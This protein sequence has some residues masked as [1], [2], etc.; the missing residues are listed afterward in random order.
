MSAAKK[1]SME[2][3][4]RKYTAEHDARRKEIREKIL[5]ARKQ[6]YM[7]ENEKVS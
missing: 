5:Q 2:A 3:T 7:N 4:Y 1:N 6:S